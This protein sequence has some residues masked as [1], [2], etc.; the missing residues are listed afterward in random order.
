MCLLHWF[1]CCLLKGVGSSGYDTRSYSDIFWILFNRLQLQNGKCYTRRVS[2]KENK[3]A[4]LFQTF[5]QDTLTD[6]SRWKAE[7]DGDFTS[8]A[9]SGT[10]FVTW[11]KSTLPSCFKAFN[12]NIYIFYSTPPPFF[13]CVS[14]FYTIQQKLLLELFQAEKLFRSMLTE[15][16]AYADHLSNNNCNFHVKMT[17]NSITVKQ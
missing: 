7:E 1:Y 17:L 6:K 12:V 9:Q 2:Y 15:D 4:S 16:K 3:D 14:S 11:C 5:I 10:Y 13:F 8:W